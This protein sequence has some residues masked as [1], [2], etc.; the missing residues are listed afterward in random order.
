M[1]FLFTDIEGSTRRWESDAD[2][3]RVA[4]ACH[5]KVLRSAIEAHDG[6]VFSHSGDGVAAAFGSPAS[7]V[8]AAIDAQRELELPVRMGIAT[9]EAELRD[10]DYFGTVLNRA[11]RVMAAG[12]GG[13]ILVA[14]STAT[15]LGGVELVDLGPGHLRDVANPISLFQ[16]HAPGLRSEFPPPRTLNASPG[17][18]RSQTTSFIG[19]GS[20]IVEIDAAIRAH[21]LV[22]LTGMGGVGKT[23]LAI[24]VATRIADEF[25]DGVWVFDLAA[26]SDP[27]AVPDAVAA[28]LGV[29]QQ[30]GRSLT[31]SVAAAQEGRIRLWVVDN[32]E[33]VLDAAA[34]VIEAVLAQ[35]A[36]VRVL[37]TSR[38]GLGVGDEQIW[39]VPALDVDAGV[40]SP[41]AVLFAERARA[42]APQFS[43]PDEAEAVVE[44]CGRLDGIPLAI[45]LAGSR[46]ASM[47]ATEVRERLNHRFRL[48]VGSRRGSRRHQTL[49][50]AVAWSYDLLSEDE[51]SLLARCSVFAGGFDLKSACAVA[52]FDNVDDYAVLDGLDALVRKSLLVAG[53]SAGRTRYSMLETIRQF[54]AEQLAASAIANEV[55]TAHPRYFAQRQAEIL[56]LWDSPRQRD[57]YDWFNSELANLRTAFRWAADHDDLD[58]AATVATDAA[59][60]GFC[61]AIYEPVA[62]AEELIE[63]AGTAN[64]P[65]LPNL[66][67]TASVCWMAGRIEEALQYTEVAQSVLADSYD[68]LPF[69]IENWLGSVYLAVGQPE[70]WAESCRAQLE[71]RRDG[72]VFVRG[73]QIFGLVFAG[74]HDPAMVAAHGMVEAAEATR[75]PFMVSFALSAYGFAFSKADPT[76]AIDALRRGLA[77]AHDNGI[78]FNESVPAVGLARL[79][80]EQGDTRAALDHLTLAIRSYHD[81]GNTSSVCTP[82]GILTWL[83]NRLERNESAAVIAGFMLS[84]LALSVVPELPAVIVRLRDALGD[85][86]YESLVTRGEAMT[87]AEV[88]AYAYDE[89]DEVRAEFDR[90]P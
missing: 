57:A 17:N 18:L 68:P 89:I 86:A 88:A 48:L 80:V 16:V 15:L 76:R 42:V 60:L 8:A 1:T 43:M 14:D 73:S 63:P 38:E 2:A 40:G 78:R 13:Q 25:P 4:L 21:R 33:H 5:D 71:R 11:A 27:A 83:L 34:D 70:L 65:L 55:Q 85:R 36:T 59:L 45:E 75:N 87:T 50:H 74:A 64:H 6:F 20:E 7:A 46:M 81:S 19:R 58:T 69:G 26:V 37:A 56:A 61:L 51:K 12:H 24:E 41:A 67:V 35:S 3:M 90:S 44:I 53:R 30:P 9:G 82:L 77:I 39:P 23:R 62:W 22:T 32:C 54:A 10:N 29:T 31:D 47:T 84:P 72:H 79:E 49:R 52:A 28:V 66:C